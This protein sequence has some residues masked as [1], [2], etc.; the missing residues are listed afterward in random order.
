MTLEILKID[1]Q[2]WPRCQV[3]NMIVDLFEAVY[4][5]TETIFVARCHQAQ[6]VVS[7]PHDV[8]KDIDPLTLEIREAFAM[9]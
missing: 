5:D 4:V 1:P 8:W 2:D 9:K 6:E 7:I 3:C